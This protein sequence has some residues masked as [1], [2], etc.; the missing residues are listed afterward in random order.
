MFNP[1]QK[2]QT[3]NKYYDNSSE[4]SLNSYDSKSEAPRSSLNKSSIPEGVGQISMKKKMIQNYVKNTLKG[5]FVH[6]QANMITTA[7]H[8]KFT[9]FKHFQKNL[10]HI[11]LY[12]A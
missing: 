6:N 7:G 5:S 1:F 11:L 4:R 10:N 2:D 12:L 8:C 9:Y 3:I